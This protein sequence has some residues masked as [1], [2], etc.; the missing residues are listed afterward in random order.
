MRF[1]EHDRAKGILV[2]RASIESNGVKLMPVSSHAKHAENR[3]KH[4]KQRIRAKLS[5]LVYPVTGKLLAHIVV[6]ATGIINKVGRKSNGGASA[7]KVRYGRNQCY[8]DH[9]LFSPSDYVEVHV[10]SDNVVTHYRRVSAI[11]L[12]PDPMNPNDWH[13]YSMETGEVFI[14][15]RK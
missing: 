12:Y 4:L 2:S 1:V 15:H 3:I 7:Y 9:Y 10:E 5:S 14:R 6:G 8:A 13:F 11:P